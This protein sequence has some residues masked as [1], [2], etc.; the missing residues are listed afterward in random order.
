MAGS[1]QTQKRITCIESGRGVIPYGYLSPTILLLAVLSFL[2]IGMVVYYSVMDN[3]IMNQNPVFVG[4]ANYVKILTDG[5]FQ[6]ALD[7]SSTSR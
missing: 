7:S 6:T 4:A 3:V 1:L 2:P 5:V